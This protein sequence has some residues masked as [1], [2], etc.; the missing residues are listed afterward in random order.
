MYAIRSYYAHKS[1][2]RVMCSTHAVFK[3]DSSSPRSFC[4]TLCSMPTSD[5]I[6]SPVLKMAMSAGYSDEA[7]EEL[8]RN[9]F[10]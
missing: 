5:S 10:V 3:N 4:T 7:I 6:T 9:N 1:A 2:P 8:A